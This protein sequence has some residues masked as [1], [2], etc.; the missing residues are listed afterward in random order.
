MKIID[1][2]FDRFALVGN[3]FFEAE[4]DL[5][6]FLDRTD[7]TIK[8]KGA[9]RVVA[10]LMGDNVYLEYDLKQG[11]DF[12]KGNF[13]IDYNP[14]KLTAEKHADMIQT[15]KP[16]LHDLHYTRIDLAFD[17]DFNLSEYAHEHTNPS[18]WAKFGGAT[19]AIETLYYG[20][21]SSD[22][23][24]R[25]YNKKLQL[26]DD[27]GLNIDDYEHYWRYE[28]EIKNR[29]AC[30]AMIEMD[31]PIFERVRFK[32]RGYEGLTGIERV[33]AQ[34]LIEHPENEGFLTQYQRSKYRKIIKQLPAEDITP[35]FE[36]ELKNKLPKLKREL[37]AWQPIPKFTDII[38]KRWY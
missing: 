16:M 25:T 21:R 10:Q 7:S 13:R 31:F 15:L 3:L 9:S 26:E 11:K 29:K 1:V 6:Y 32:K 5:Q 30:E 35:I 28:L 20:S 34:S 8:S 4:S 18:K 12:K 14:S 2:K 17:C 36:N 22:Y 23:Y 38:N 37:R 33:V 27:G 19:G 24:S